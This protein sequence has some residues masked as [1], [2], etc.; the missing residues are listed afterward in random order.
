LMIVLTRLSE[1]VLAWSAAKQ[2]N[3][4]DDSQKISTLGASYI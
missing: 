2:N 3:V 1:T 4:A